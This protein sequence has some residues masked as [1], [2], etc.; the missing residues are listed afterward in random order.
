MRLLLLSTTPQVRTISTNGCLGE[1]LRDKP[2]FPLRSNIRECTTTPRD[3]ATCIHSGAGTTSEDSDTAGDRMAYL[4]A[5]IRFSLAIGYSIRF[6]AD[7]RSLAVN[8]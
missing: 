8:P 3:S 5:G 2:R 7:G 1:S 4:L 6:L